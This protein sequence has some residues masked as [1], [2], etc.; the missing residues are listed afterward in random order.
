M[1]TNKG[2]V[3]CD[4]ETYD[5]IPSVNGARQWHDTPRAK[6]NGERWLQGLESLPNN[7]KPKPKIKPERKTKP[8]SPEPLE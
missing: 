6:I 2:A 3:I 8:D 1:L 7:F 5:W 4:I